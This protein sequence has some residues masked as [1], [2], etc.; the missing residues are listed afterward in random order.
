VLIDDLDLAQM[1]PEAVDDLLGL[2]HRL[3]RRRLRDLL[4]GSGLLY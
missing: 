3:D 1:V 2:D 4:L